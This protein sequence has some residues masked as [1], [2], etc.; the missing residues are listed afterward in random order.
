MHH[1]FEAVYQQFSEHYPQ[2]I[3][4]WIGSAFAG[5]LGDDAEAFGFNPARACDHVGVVNAPCQH[6]K[7][8]E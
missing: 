2:S 8:L 1:D 5:R 7:T 6:Y 4:V 3:E